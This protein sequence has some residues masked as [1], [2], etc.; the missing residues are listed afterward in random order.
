MR[1]LACFALTFCAAAC[2]GRVVGVVGSDAGPADVAP[3]QRGA[4]DGPSVLPPPPDAPTTPPPPVD[5]VAVDVPTAVDVAVERPGMM[6][7]AAPDVIV[8]RTCQVANPNCPA[9]SYCMSA[10]CVTGTCVVAPTSDQESP[11]CGCDRF[12]YWNGAV[13]A[14]NA[15]S[16]RIAGACPAGVTCGGNAGVVCAGPAICNLEQASAIACN[17]NNPTGRCWVLPDTCPALPAGTTP[18]TRRCNSN[19]ACQTVC[20]LITSGRAYFVDPTCP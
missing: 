16:I 14:A 18:T 4:A 20:D 8:A 19:N 2:G 9:G 7:D 6:V 1:K 5:A 3:P 15:A 17:V 13:A 10:N 11:L 12:T